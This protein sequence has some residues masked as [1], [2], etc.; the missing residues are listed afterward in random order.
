MSEIKN[1]LESELK[2]YE[3]NTDIEAIKTQENQRKKKH[4]NVALMLSSLV[5][6]FTVALIPMLLSNTGTNDPIEEPLYGG[7]SHSF[8][9]VASALDSETG[10]IVEATVDSANLPDE[11]M[12]M[13]Q[14]GL[15]CKYFV[16]GNEKYDGIYFP[17]DEIMKEIFTQDGLTVKKMF[18]TMGAETIWVEGE[19]IIKVEYEVQKGALFRVTDQIKSKKIIQNK[20]QVYN[21]EK[22]VMW[23]PT[24]DLF[25]WM[26]EQNAHNGPADYSTAPKDEI[27]ITVTFSDMS[28]V[29]RKLKLYYNDYGSLVVETEDGTKFN[30]G[31][32]NS[33]KNDG[34][35]DVNEYDENGNPINWDYSGL[36]IE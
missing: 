16:S 18:S 36:E 23:R 22:E 29:T 34:Y 9:I 10:N 35:N 33:H 7:K 30:D 12:I 4:R 19:E 32:L 20:E 11:D 8:F 2:E 31:K 13:V 1:R 21:D 28:V 27:S 15:L 14:T 24:E 25:K 26:E 3:F 17:D 5:V 6:V